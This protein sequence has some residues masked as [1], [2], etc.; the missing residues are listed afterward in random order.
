VVKLKI[1]I[2]IAIITMG[3]PT[4]ALSTVQFMASKDWLLVYAPEGVCWNR[5][6]Q[7]QDDNPE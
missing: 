4:D 1:K 2:T 6:A 5:T 3:A 7:A